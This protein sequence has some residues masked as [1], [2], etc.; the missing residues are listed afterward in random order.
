[1]GEG[2]ALGEVGDE[3]GEE[4][5]REGDAREA[6]QEGVSVA[7]R[8]GDEAVEEFEGDDFEEPEANGGVRVCVLW[9][10]GR[11]ERRNLHGWVEDTADEDEAAGDG[12]VVDVGGRECEGVVDE[13]VVGA[14]EEDGVDE[15]HAQEKRYQ[16]ERGHLVFGEECFHANVTTDEAEDNDHGAHRRGP[17]IYEQCRLVFAERPDRRR[18]GVE[19]HGDMAMA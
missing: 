3:D 8:G 18:G 6:Q 11:L 1:M 4:G 9:G 13:D 10:Q 15:C 12:A 5:Q 16:G 14:V 2:L 17:P 7:A 19:P